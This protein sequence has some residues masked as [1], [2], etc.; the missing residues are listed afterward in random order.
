MKDRL[1]WSTRRQRVHTFVLL[2]IRNSSWKLFNVAISMFLFLQWA[3]ELLKTYRQL[4]NEKKKATLKKR[5]ITEEETLQIVDL[6][7]VVDSAQSAGCGKDEIARTDATTSTLF[8]NYNHRSSTESAKFVSCCSSNRSGP[9]NE[10][11]EEQVLPN[12]DFRNMVC[13]R[14]KLFNKFNSP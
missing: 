11:E 13:L 7:N 8:P 9:T 12:A 2:S 10:D 3:A 5:K 6:Q 1:H 4:Q 14:P